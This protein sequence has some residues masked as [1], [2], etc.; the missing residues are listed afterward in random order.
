MLPTTSDRFRQI[1][2]GSELPG[3]GHT[4]VI[5]EPGQGVVL[6]VEQTQQQFKIY[7]TQL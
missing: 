2:S 7:Q 4:A 3:G 1:P 6:R 5:L